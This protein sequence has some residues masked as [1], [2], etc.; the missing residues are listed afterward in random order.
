MGISHINDLE[1]SK[2]IDT[3]RRLSN[4]DKSLELSIKFDGSANLG[5]GLDDQGRLYFDRSVKGQSEYRRGPDDWPKK[6]MYNALRTAVAALLKNK[7]VIEKNM[8]PGDYTDCEVMFEYMPNSIEYDGNN[9]VILHNAE[10]D[11]L[12]RKL[13]PVRIKIDLYL[14]N[15][16]SKKIEKVNAHVEYKFSGKQVLN[17]K[18]YKISINDDIRKLE[19]FLNAKNGKFRDLSNFDVLQLRAVGKDSQK[20][21]SEKEVLM[22]KISSMKLNIKNKLIVQILNNTPAGFGSKPPQFDKQGNNIG[23]TF[24]EGVVLKDLKTGD[25]SKIVSVFPTINKFLWLY[26]EKAMKGIGKGDEYIPGVMTMFINDISNAFGIK[27]L[28]APGVISRINSKYKGEVANAKLLM[29]L[30]DSGFNFNKVGQTRSKFISAIN[31]AQKNIKNLQKEFE[32]KGKESILKVR[33]PKFKRDVKYT[34][35]VIRKTFETFEMINDELREYKSAIENTREIT[36][37]GNAVQLLRIFLGQKNL[38]RLSESNSYIFEAKNPGVS[39]GVIV[40]RFQPP[41]KGHIKVIENAIRKNDRVALFIAGQVYDKDRNPIPFSL[42]KKMIKDAVKSPKLHVY[43]A[44]TGF[45]P[46]LIDSTIDLSG[47]G[48][49]NIFAG[50]D[51]INGYKQQMKKYWEND[52]INWNVIELKRPRNAVSATKVRAAIRSRDEDKFREYVPREL[53]GYW[54]KLQKHVKESV[55]RTLIKRIIRESYK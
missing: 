35:V 51:R 3:L 27:A 20:I 31:K 43:E 17:T 54:S 42:R 36:N 19:K 13:R 7:S 32:S 41:Q 5:F 11:A 21:K 2:F 52:N 9:Y 34:D 46:Q 53:W 47:V 23:G 14:Y 28:R 26:R 29:F 12:A 1:I 18:K 16:L 22:Q 4:K 39:V 30:K 45:I 38:N 6:P 25:L 10:F 8:K 40:G 37:E 55:I 50:S 24:P 33:A 49:I 48:K 44:K 15:S